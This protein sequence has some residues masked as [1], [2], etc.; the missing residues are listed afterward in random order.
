MP[1]NLG[2]HGRI[3]DVK[4][5]ELKSNSRKLFTMEQIA[6]MGDIA[7]ARITLCDA[8]QDAVGQVFD[9]LGNMVKKGWRVKEVENYRTSPKLSYVSQ[10]TLDNFE[11]LCNNHKQYPEIVSKARENAYTAVHVGFELPDGKIIELQIMGR[12]LEKTKEV[13]DLYYKWA[14]NKGLP[15]KYAPIQRLFDDILPNLNE[16]QKQALEMYKKDSYLHALDMPVK[17]AK[18]K[19]N[20]EKDYFLPLP[21]FLPQEL[22]YANLNKMMEDCNRVAKRKTK[23]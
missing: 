14:C 7:G 9:I 19:P 13:E 5:I 12:D 10:S 6:G 20:Y 8:S 11:A 4:G 3:K 17:S 16:F 1:G 22:S 15:E 21:Y 23:A 18:H 2:I